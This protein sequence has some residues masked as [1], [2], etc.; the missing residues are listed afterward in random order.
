MDITGGNS[1]YEQARK[2]G[3][4]V[5]MF[6]DDT[7]NADRKKAKK[8]NKGKINPRARTQLIKRIERDVQTLKSMEPR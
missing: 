4:I 1:L 5:D 6:L 8:M 3:G 7:V 2:E